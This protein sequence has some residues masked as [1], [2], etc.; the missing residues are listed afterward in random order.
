MDKDCKQAWKTGY[1]KACGNVGT[2]SFFLVTLMLTQQNILKQAHDKVFLGVLIYIL[3]R[4]AFCFIT[5]VCCKQKC[6]G[7]F[8]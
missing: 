8:S 2:I 1:I 3:S 7:E 6:L 5:A 4:T